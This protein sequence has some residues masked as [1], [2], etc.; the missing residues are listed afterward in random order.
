MTTPLS[1]MNWLASMHTGGLQTICQL[2]KSTS[3]TI[4]ADRKN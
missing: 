2:A 4:P 1:P 3:G